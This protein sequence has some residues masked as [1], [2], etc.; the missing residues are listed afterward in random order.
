MDTE[1]MRDAKTE[2]SALAK[3]VVLALLWGVIG[4]TALTAVMAIWLQVLLAA[5][6]VAITVHLLRLKTLPKRS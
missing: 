3:I 4:H 1:K 5:I 2:V 6:A